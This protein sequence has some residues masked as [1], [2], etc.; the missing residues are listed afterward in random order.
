MKVKIYALK[1]GMALSL[2]LQ[3]KSFLKVRGEK[4]TG[5]EKKKRKKSQSDFKLTF[6]NFMS[7]RNSRCGI[8]EIIQR[9]WTNQIA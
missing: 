9:Q 7:M 8:R 6:Y 5:K 3:R 4:K 1:R 2:M